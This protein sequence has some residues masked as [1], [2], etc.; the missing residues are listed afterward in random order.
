MK[1]TDKAD[2]KYTNQR[3]EILTF[4]RENALQTVKKGLVYF[5]IHESCAYCAYCA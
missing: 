3:V 5:G 4:L 2:M 1:T